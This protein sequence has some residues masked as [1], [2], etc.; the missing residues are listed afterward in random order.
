MLS[1]AFSYWFGGWSSIIALILFLTLNYFVGE[2]YLSRRYEAF[3][4]DYQVPPT[5][6]SIHS[7]T[8]LNDSTHI[9]RDRQ[10]TLVM[11]ENWKN[12]FPAG[13]KPKMVFLCA[14]GG[15]KRAALWALTALQTADSLT[16]GKL[17]NNS[18]LITR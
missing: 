10:A 8:A 12:K 7:L 1:G 11:L 3:G 9:N 2:D 18:V 5:E 14:S 4:L 15:G 13:T 17:I 16:G 6:Y